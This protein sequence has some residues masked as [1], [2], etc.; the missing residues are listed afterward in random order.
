MTNTTSAAKASTVRPPLAKGDDG[1]AN[2]YPVRR[3]IDG[4]AIV[5]PSGQTGFRHLSPIV[6][7]YPSN[8]CEMG[9]EDECPNR[10]THWL[11]APASYIVPMMLC[12]EHVT[13]EHAYFG[14]TI[15]GKYDT[16][17]AYDR[18]RDDDL[19]DRV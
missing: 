15:P 11:T 13:A 19:T 8:V 16:I 10:P 4:T 1:S 5:L 2:Q 3:V 9:D 7:D 18:Q 6:T 14:T 17:E 12:D